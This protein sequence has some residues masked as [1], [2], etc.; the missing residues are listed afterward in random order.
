MPL[1]LY[2]IGAFFTAFILAPT[3]NKR[4]KRKRLLY[5]QDENQNNIE[6]D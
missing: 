4:C 1:R 3:I 6:D 5:K 2:R